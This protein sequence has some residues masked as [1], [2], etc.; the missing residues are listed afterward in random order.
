MI[1]EEL[2]E[3]IKT[4]FPSI[5]YDLEISNQLNSLKGILYNAELY[6]LIPKEDLMSLLLTHSDKYRDIRGKGKI[7]DLP[8]SDRLNAQDLIIISCD[9]SNMIIR[10]VTTEFS[11]FDENSCLLFLD[12]DFIVYYVTPLQYDLLLNGED[13]VFR[14]YDPLIYFKRVLY[15]ALSVHCS[16][17]HFDNYQ[18]KIE[19]QEELMGTKMTNGVFKIYYRILNDYVEQPKFRLNAEFNNK[20]IETVVREKT[21]APEGDLMTSHGVYAS[22]LN[23]LN[24]GSCSLRITCGKTPSGFTCV[25]RVTPLS[26][27]NMRIENLGFNRKA[28]DFLENLSEKERGLTLF[29]GPVRS[30]KNTSMNA[31]VNS[32]RDKKNLKFIEFSNPVESLQPFAQLDYQGKQEVLLDFVRLSKK[33]DVNIAILNELPTKEVAG[34]VVDLINSSIG[35]LTTF[36][37][38]RIWDFPYKLKDYFG[39]AYIDLITH[40]NGIMNQKMFIKQCPHCR[41]ITYDES[42]LRDDVKEF[43]MENDIKTYYRSEGCSKCGYTGLA[44]SVQPYV[45]FLYFTDEIKRKLLRCDKPYQMEDLIREYV[46]ENKQSLEFAIADAIR[47]GDL[48]PRDLLKIY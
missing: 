44:N 22:W 6:D 40:I 13:Y 35:V 29:T 7:D 39:D 2:K 43:L 12:Y 26:I 4:K 9:N 30:G 47:I 14:V 23:P 20:V 18:K 45:E 10:A 8:D 38:D 46:I 37:I 36:H 16:D 31:L 25:I 1:E 28:M 32:I 41:K 42:E 3:I 5:Y 33:Q 15:D 27:S 24:D 48:H 17:I 19:S 11:D 21:L 34:E